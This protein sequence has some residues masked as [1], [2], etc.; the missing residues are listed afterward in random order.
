MSSHTTIRIGRFAQFTLVL[1]TLALSACAPTEPKPALDVS[2]QATKVD[3]GAP[4]LISGPGIDP[5]DVAACNA[6]GGGLQHVCLMGKIACVVTFADAGKACTD[7]SQC[8]SKRCLVEY[9][10]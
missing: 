7:G 2:P 10:A 5:D 4:G 9:S 6:K 1:C 3:Q 8:E